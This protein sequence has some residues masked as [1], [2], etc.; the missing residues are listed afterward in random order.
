MYTRLARTFDSTLLRLARP[1]LFD[2]T[3]ARTV[4]GIK[5]YVS[6]A[7]LDDVA[8][9]ETC[10]LTFS[11]TCTLSAVTIILSR[12]PPLTPLLPLSTGNILI[13]RTGNETPLVN[14]L[15]LEGSAPLQD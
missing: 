15:T 14:E 10:A 6:Q 5:V 2:S 12:T 11:K 3:P 7:G 4:A 1:E 13:Y 9:F 8:C